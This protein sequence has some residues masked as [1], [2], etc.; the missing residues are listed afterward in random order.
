MV[1]RQ[2]LSVFAVG[3]HH[4]RR[5]RSGVVAVGI[6]VAVHLAIGFYLIN[7]TF[8]PF[9]LPAPPDEPR[10]IDAQTLTLQPPRPIDQ[11]KPMTPR[12]AVRAS[13]GP[14]SPNIET[15]AVTPTVSP[16]PDILSPP[17][18][19]LGDGLTPTII[20]P[21]TTATTITNPDWL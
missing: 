13:E 3:P 5:N 21:T 14:V 20:E 6:S 18:A 8:H 7:V 10:S 1:I 2:S 11:I 12:T 4:P 17:P 15:L 9:N 19:G 16:P